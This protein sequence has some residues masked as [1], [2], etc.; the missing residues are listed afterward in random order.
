[1]PEN[2]SVSTAALRTTTGITFLAGVWL[3]ISPWV[4][5]VYIEQNAW[6]GWIVGAI[7]AIFALIRFSNPESAQGLSYLNM[8]LGAWTFASPWIYRYTGDTARMVNSLCVGVIVFALA[9]YGA[10]HTGH[11]VSGPTPH[12]PG[13]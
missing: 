8:L 5:G 9:S 4:Y 6:N 3:F 7:I 10:S 13:V 1:M 2:N 11:S 12:S